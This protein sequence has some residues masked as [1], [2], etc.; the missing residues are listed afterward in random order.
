MGTTLGQS[1]HGSNGHELQNWSL[2]T[3]FLIS[4]NFSASENFV[5]THHV[6]PESLVSGS[7][8]SKLWFIF[9]RLATKIFNHRAIDDFS[10]SSFFVLKKLG[11]M[12]L[13]AI[14]PLHTTHLTVQVISEHHVA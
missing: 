3:K 11:S 6:L 10:L 14:T 12:A 7:V 5:K 1:E 8:L 2:A 13:P 9:G 4:G